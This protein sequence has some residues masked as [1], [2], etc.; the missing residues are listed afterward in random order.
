M[1]FLVRASMLSLG[2]VT[3][4]GAIYMAAETPGPR[5]PPQ[6]GHLF[7]NGACLHCSLVS[8]PYRA[9][10]DPDFVASSTLRRSTAPSGFQNS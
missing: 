9:R 2:R 3:S 7:G 5:P 6:R 4:N 10:G 1:P 8:S